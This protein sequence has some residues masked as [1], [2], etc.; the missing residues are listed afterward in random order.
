MLTEKSQGAEAAR[1]A[2]APTANPLD[3][4]SYNFV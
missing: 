4:L 3:D 2:P 1:P